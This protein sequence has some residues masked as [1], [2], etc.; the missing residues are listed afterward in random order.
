MPVK[1]L[2]A[3]VSIDI[4]NTGIKPSSLEKTREM[5]VTGLR[6][7]EAKLPQDKTWLAKAP[8]GVSRM[9]I[10][11]LRNRR[12]PCVEG[13]IQRKLAPAQNAP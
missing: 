1:A 5:R 7:G 6:L 8:G 2:G 3:D 11:E 12:S 10:P 9:P 4:I 13:S